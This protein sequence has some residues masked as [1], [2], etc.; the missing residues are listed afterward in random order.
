MN[1]LK[2]QIGEKIEASLTRFKETSSF[3]AIAKFMSEN[4]DNTRFW[5]AQP[6]IFD[7]A[8]QSNTSPSTVTRYAQE[9]G[10]S[11]FKELGIVMHNQSTPT[12]TKGWWD[13][14]PPGF[15]QHD[16]WVDGLIDPTAALNLPTLKLI[17]QELTHKDRIYFFGFERL[18]HLV[19]PALNPLRQKGYEVY[20]SQDDQQQLIYSETLTATDIAIVLPFTTAKI[21][22]DKILQR[23]G[24]RQTALILITKNWLNFELTFIKQKY[25]LRISGI[26]DRYFRDGTNEATILFLLKLVTETLPPRNS[27]SS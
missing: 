14:E 16:Y 12:S 5:S 24:K 18:S 27:S 25:L 23:I 17:H 9:L 6:S 20:A 8:V 15:F 7:V 26:E 22:Y 3:F 19:K 21:S 10:L 4:K 11:G 1:V 13:V 2:D